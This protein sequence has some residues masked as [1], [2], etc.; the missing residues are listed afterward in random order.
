MSVLH[1]SRALN[2]GAGRAGRRAHLACQAVGI[3]S[4]FAFVQGD[5]PGGDAFQVKVAV[6]GPDAGSAKLAEVL[7]TG[8][9]WGALIAQRTPLTNTLLS[10]PYPGIELDHHR[11]FDTAE[12]IHL[13]W[14]TYAVTPR[15]LANW[16]ATG[17]VVFWTLHD[18]NAMTGGCHYP[19]DCVQYQTACMKCPQLSEDPGFVP[20]SFAE[21]RRMYSEGGALCIVTPSRWLADCAGRSSILGGR[22]ITVVPNPI[23]IDVFRPPGDR[24]ALRAGIGIGQD[25]FVLLV[26]GYDVVEKRKGF[27]ILRD[28]LSELLASGALSDCLPSPIANA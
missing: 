12:I 3:E 18:F 21:K 16:L 4:N 15:Q 23:E 7:T 22:P 27:T 19:V 17:R 13:H 1:F 8:F 25:D 14:P 9:Q 11:L 2:G 28:A 5:A 6:D 20:N 26:G 24:N 10:I